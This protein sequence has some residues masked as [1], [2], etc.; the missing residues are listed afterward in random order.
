MDMK[1]EVK[2]TYD[3]RIE[4]TREDILELVHNKLGGKIGIDITK[5]PQSGEKIKVFVRIPGGG[6][7][8]NTNLDIEQDTP[9]VVNIQWTS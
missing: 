3:K 8:S 9:I 7:Y 6:D 1:E 4:V 5:K 2:R